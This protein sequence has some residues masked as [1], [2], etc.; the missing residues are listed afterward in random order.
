MA[1]QLAK[2]S[3]FATKPQCHVNTSDPPSYYFRMNYFGGSG[4]DPFGYRAG[5][6][7]QNTSTKERANEDE[8]IISMA[9]WM[10]QVGA[11]YLNLT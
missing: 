7:T 11:V 8:R 6:K 1:K 10:T 2:F 4:H 3:K 5:I 9:F